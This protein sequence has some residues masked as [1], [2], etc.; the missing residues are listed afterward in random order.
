[1][2]SNE[3][4]ADSSSPAKNSAANSP[5][6]NPAKSSV[7]NTARPAVLAAVAMLAVVAID[8]GRQWNIV[9]AVLVLLICFV[10]FRRHSKEAEAQAEGGSGDGSSD[11]PNGQS[12][13]PYSEVALAELQAIGSCIGEKLPDSAYGV[14]EETDQIQVLVADAVATLND[15]FTT[16]REDTIAQRQL[17]EGMISALSDGVGDGGDEDRVTIGSFIRSSAELMASFVALT[18]AAS[19]QSLELVAN[20]DEMSVH[21]D[22]MIVRLSD[23]SVIADQT[24][25][26]SLNATIEAARAGKM[27]RGFGV[28]ADEVRFLSQNSNE[29][30]DQIREQ[31]ELMQSS[32]QRT[33]EAVHASASHDAEVLVHGKTDLEFMTAQVKELEVSLGEQANQAAELTDRIGRSTADAVRSLQFEDIVRQVAEHAGKRVTSLADF[34][35]EVPNHLDSLDEVEL[36]QAREQVTAAIEELALH[37]PAE[38]ESLDSGEIELF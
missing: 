10:S 34:L 7:A 25:L 37:A 28:V 24:R 17:I 13:S 31:L 27:G 36:A 32:M 8:P 23:M 18:T 20:I 4:E 16:I 35:V 30:N 11:D 22:D 3:T 19:E 5:A 1:M 38:Q 9:A 26:L 6:E 15:S 21:V 12:A 29:F 2:T 14:R 33:R